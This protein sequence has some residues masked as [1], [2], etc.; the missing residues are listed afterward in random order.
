MPADNSIPYNQR[1]LVFFDIESSGLSAEKHEI[2][3]LAAVRIRP[4]FSRQTHVMSRRVRMLRPEDAEP[5]AL[6]VNG[7]NARDWADAVHVR[8]ALVEFASVID[9]DVMLVGHN[10]A[11]FDWPFIV[12]AFRREQLAL[13][14]MKYCLDTASMAWPLVVRGHLDKINLETLCARYG[15]S[16]YGQHR[17]MADV[18]RT[19]AVY[20]KLLG[21]PQPSFIVGGST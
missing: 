7:Y 21:L 15:V 8:V 11:R 4:D 6:E 19:V 3:D 20:C 9:P 16:N 5:K 13:P 2:L 17:A 18:R 1:D 14:D 10:A 12:E